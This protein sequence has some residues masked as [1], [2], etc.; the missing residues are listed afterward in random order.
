MMKTKRNLISIAL[1]SALLLV[2]VL[3]ALPVIAQS[4]P[5]CQN[6]CVTRAKAAAATC[7]T[8]PPSQQVACLEGV[9]DELNVCLA[10]CPKR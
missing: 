7:L 3:L 8:L 2:A 5:S 4:P 9:Q 1:L 6:A 10:N